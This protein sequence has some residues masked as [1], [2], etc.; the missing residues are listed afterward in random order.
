MTWETLRRQFSLAGLRHQLLLAVYGERRHW[1]GRR[2]PRALFVWYGFFAIAPWLLRE[3]DALIGVLLLVVG[4]AALARINRLVLALL[5]IGIVGDVAGWGLV[6]ILFGGDL[7]VFVALSTLVL[8]LATVSLASITLFAALDPDRLSD[9]LLALGVP[10]P[11]IFGIAYAYR[12]VP[13]YIEEFDQVIHA[14]RLRVGA[15]APGWLHWRQIW[16]TIHLII[17]SFYPMI[18]NTAR[19]T[20]T[21]YEALETRGFGHALSHPA[22]RALRL[23]TL[24]LRSGAVV[25]VGGSLAGFFL[26]LAAA[27]RW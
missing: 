4:V 21:S 19:R 3:R 25:F 20:R 13:L 18:L 26:V 22:A 24:K 15:P 2:D 6:A 11:I 12:M 9:G 23:A 7:G 14:R 8:K 1:L 27:A 16:H 17:M 5:G 10:Q